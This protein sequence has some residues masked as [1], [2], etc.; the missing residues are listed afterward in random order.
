MSQLDQNQI[1]TLKEYGILKVESRK[2]AT[3]MDEI[4]GEVKQILVSV[5]A[6]DNPVEL[7]DIGK[8]KL[9][10]RKLW[11]YSEETQRL[12]EELK[13]KQAFERSTGKATLDYTHDIYFT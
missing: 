3:R 7:K 10:E 12:E 9:R 11:T 8:L 4:K 2:L 5:D 1:D 13:Q 6:Q